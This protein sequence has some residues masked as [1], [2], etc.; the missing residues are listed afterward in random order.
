MRTSHEQCE[1]SSP[2][3]RSRALVRFADR[4][5]SPLKQVLQNRSGLTVVR[6]VPLPPCPPGSV[7]VRNSYSAIS[8][9]TERSRAELSQKSL[10]SKAR[11][12][13]DLVRE[14]VQR[15]RR[16]GL[17]STRDAVKRKLDEETA[18]GYSSAGTVIEIGAAVRGVR[19]GDR[20]ACAGGGHANHA[21]VVSMPA[22]LIAKVPDEVPLEAAALATIAAI[23]LHGIRLSGVTVGDSVA[24]IGCGLV[25]QIACRLL[26]A[27]GARVFAL[28]IDP[29][30][31][32][33]ARSS[34]DEA[35]VANRRA[36]EKVRMANGDAGVDH[37]LLTA[38]APSNEPLVLATEMA[39]D[40]ASIVLVGVVPIEIPRAAM[41]DKEL[42][43]R[44]SRSYGP[45]RYDLEYEERGLDYPIGYVRWTEQRNMECVLELQASGRLDLEDLVETV[46][47]ERAAEAYQRLVAE[48]SERPL[49]ALVLAY[50][51]TSAN[52][53]GDLTLRKLEL[54]TAD[55]HPARRAAGPV[56]VGLL[57]PGGFAARVLVPALVAG[58][59][60]LVAAAG[61]TGPSAE[62]A[63]RSLGFESVAASEE[64]LIADDTVDA[65]VIATR[66]ASHAALVCQALEAGK[67]VFCEKPLALTLEELDSV[68]H[69][70]ADSTGI[71]AVGFNRRFAPLLR[72][73]RDFVLSPPSPVASAYRVSAGHLPADHW[74]H[75]LEQGGG[76]LIGECCHFIDSLVF[77][78]GSEVE[79]VH[80]AGYGNSHLPVQ[81]RDNVAV[82]LGFANGSV[83]SI[84]YVADGS[85]RVSKE[86]LE[87][88]SGDRSAILDDYRTLALYGADRNESRGS[89][90]Q[91]KG[92]RLEI[93]A[94]LRGIEHGEAPVPLGEVANVS[95][96]TLAVVESLRTGQTIHVTTAA[97]GRA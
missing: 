93:E 19:V 29:L 45:G 83:G 91:E 38:A 41:Y 17:R 87:A 37:V 28:D 25:G 33:Q 12:R 11:E 20:V 61:G 63:T 1:R 88:F 15:A 94:F 21:E 3:N 16:E 78:T 97:G 70:A 57:G 52:G 24:V 26:R 69:A 6:N 53:S 48:P 64:A 79:E 76:R 44:V 59:A 18:V 73:L 62:A 86:R 82:T 77:L 66:H 68:V 74:T 81:A 95:L 43:F 13:P 9:G 39:R 31:V 54:E 5:Q 46:P 96:A 40:R 50:G 47:V 8:S 60:R 85:G 92:H 42:S 14:V 2:E 71:L 89:R 22:N 51:D 80:A 84:L 56:R 23:P 10:L 4:E 58:G 55:P 67:H 36:A 72:D 30:R 34:A 90:S 35:F 49:G 65:V 27:S 75:D 32:E 7:L